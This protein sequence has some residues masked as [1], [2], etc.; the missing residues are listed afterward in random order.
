M[1][2]LRAAATQAKLEDDADDAKIEL[3][4]CCLRNGCDARYEGEQSKRD[5]C[6]F[7]SKL[8]VRS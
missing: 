8:L 7:H 6:L 3:G 2:A 5:E 1:D 4:A